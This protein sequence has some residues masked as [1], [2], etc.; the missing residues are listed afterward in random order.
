MSNPWDPLVSQLTPL[1]KSSLQDLVDLGKQEVQSFITKQ[2][3]QYAKQTWLSIN[4]SSDDEK[5]EAVDNLKHLKAQVVVDAM[6][7]QIVASARILGLLTKAF[8][9][10]EAFLV[11][12]GP[13]IIAAL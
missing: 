8:N 10:V 7:L 3:E 11:Q 12:Y 13:L 4:A 9:V 6:D 2:A 5:A 1:L